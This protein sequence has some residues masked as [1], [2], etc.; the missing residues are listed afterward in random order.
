MTLLYILLAILLLGVLIMV[1]EW[2]HYYAA[3]LCGI[4]VKEFSIGFG[5]AI[6]SWKSKKNG[7]L[8]AIRPIPLGG[9]CMFYGDTDDDPTGTKA[10]DDPRNY[11]KVPVWKR[12]ISVF[13]GPLMNFIFAFVV[14]IGLMTFYGMTPTAP[15]I[16]DVEAN[17]PAQ[18]AGLMPGDIFLEINDIALPEGTV[19]EVINAIDSVE[20][21]AS[22]NFTVQRGEEVVETTVYPIYDSELKIYRIGITLQQGAERLPASQI[23][24][25]A[26][27]SCVQ[28]SVA[29]ANALGDL[30]TTG[31]GFDQTAGP[32]GVIQL[33]AE[34]TQIGGF[35]IFLQLMVIISI[36]L[37]LINLLPIPALDG[38]RLIFMIIEAIRR[39]PISQRIESIVHTVG[40][41]FLLGLMLLFTYKDIIRL[42]GF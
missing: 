35:N 8:F 30:F 9:Y 38:S 39:K 23:I 14:A 22:I 25:A 11:N 7:T 31:A 18:Q 28:A 16:T 34:Q 37:G 26:F 13:A 21:G 15:F 40:Y 12:M 10:I 41:V 32:V 2:G 4:A 36:N 1:H 6:F 3:R 29:I 19:T 24:P 5:P 33:V 27:D 20:E 17:L 42:L